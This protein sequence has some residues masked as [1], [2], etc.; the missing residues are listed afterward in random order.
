MT[1]EQIN[2][3]IF[4]VNKNSPLI[5]LVDKHCYSTIS[6]KLNYNTPVLKNH[7]ILHHHLYDVIN[8]FPRNTL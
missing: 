2:S 6:S 7:H 1:N 3:I 8:D 5:L 4:Q